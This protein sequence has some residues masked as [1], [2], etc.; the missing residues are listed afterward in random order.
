M[1]GEKK[2]QERQTE[3]K[4]ELFIPRGS[5]R[6]EP[7]FLIGLNGKNYL[8]PKGKKSFVPP[9]VKAEYERSLRAQEELDNRKDE[10]IAAGR[11][12]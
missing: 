1:A 7:N 9:A 4:V 8:L 3:E 2:T 10:L 6:D 5:D 12:R 11:K